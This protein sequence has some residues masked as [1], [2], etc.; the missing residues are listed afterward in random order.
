M[1]IIVYV[2]T[3]YKHNKSINVVFWYLSKN[4]GDIID[5]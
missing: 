2:V 1:I 3:V 4:S 5:D